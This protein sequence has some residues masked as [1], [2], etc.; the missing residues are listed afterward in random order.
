LPACLVLVGWLGL[1][2][3]AYGVSLDE[4]KSR[5]ELA[6]ENLRVSEATEARI[7][8]ELKELRDSGNASPEAIIDH[9]TYL[10]RAQQMVRENREIVKQMEAIYPRHAPP[11]QQPSGSSASSPGRPT[12]VT[13]IPEEEESDALASLEREFN[14]SLAAFD[15]MLLKEWDEMLK[16]SAKKMRALGEDSSGAGSR[17][18]GKGEEA[19]GAGSQS[20]KE[21]EEAQAASGEGTS[22]GEEGTAESGGR[23][24]AGAEGKDT[25]ETEGETGPSEA[26]GEGEGRTIT[27]KDPRHPGEQDDDIVA[28]QLREA[29]EKETDPKLKEKLWKEYEEYKKG[30]PP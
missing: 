5:L 17:S 26:K 22:Q 7:A 2:T 11:S 24:M 9:E 16:R 14:E 19:S 21:G 10:V 8:S 15:E 23:E 4:L 1:A 6:R 30:S 28:R 13:R 20:G 3:W 29:A 12:P 27:K 18:G 25:Q